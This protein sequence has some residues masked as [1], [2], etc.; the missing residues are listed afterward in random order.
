MD[1][2][3]VD[4]TNET[5]F[6]GRLK[7]LRNEKGLSQ[8]ELGDLIG[9]HSNHVSRYER[10]ESKPTAKSLKAIAEVLKVSTDYL[11]DGDEKG[12]TF[13]NLKDKELLEMFTDVENLSESKKEA[14][15]IVI[16]AI[17]KEEKY[18]QLSAS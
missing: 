18:Q 14:I 12:A 4:T 15:K 6:A 11:Y 2:Y 17:I 1:N 10:G 3:G 8:A 7:K 13:A 9:L 5:G 16:K